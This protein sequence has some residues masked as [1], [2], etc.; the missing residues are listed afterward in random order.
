M[1][2]FK[3]NAGKLSFVALLLTVTAAMFYVPVATSNNADT[4]T[5]VVPTEVVIP[6]AS[7]EECDAMIQGRWYLVYD[8]YQYEK[9][10]VSAMKATRAET[11]RIAKI[12]NEIETLRNAIK[13]RCIVH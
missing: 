4:I 11:V 5:T 8:L 3:D 1:R 2:L 7:D 10:D 6:T 9:T 13:T 12:Y